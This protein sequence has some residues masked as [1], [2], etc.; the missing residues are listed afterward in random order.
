MLT[1]ATPSADLR[2]QFLDMAADFT[3]HGELPL[4][5]LSRPSLNG[6][7][8]GQLDATLKTDESTGCTRCKRDLPYLFGYPAVAS[9][10]ELHATLYRCKACGTFYEQGEGWTGP[11]P[12][13]VEYVQVH[14]P[15][16]PR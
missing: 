1:L 15:G 14:Y 4:R 9:S 3:A 7:N 12:V 8:V 11:T 6:G 10:S 13:D 2:G 5:S 16:V